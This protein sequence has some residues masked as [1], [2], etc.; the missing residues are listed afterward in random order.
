MIQDGEYIREKSTGQLH[1]VF[2]S[3]HD[4]YHTFR[5]SDK[6]NAVVKYTDALHVTSPAM[7]PGDPEMVEKER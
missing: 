1:K 4:G 3:A 7:I 2:F 6:R 5:F